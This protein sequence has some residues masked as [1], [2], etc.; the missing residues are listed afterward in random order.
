MTKK[1][2]SRGTQSLGAI[3]LVLIV[4]VAAFFVLG[5]EAAKEVGRAVGVDVSP[6]IDA[7]SGPTP[8]EQGAGGS[9]G[10]AVTEAA[11]G[12]GDFWQVYFTEPSQ[13][14]K[15]LET[16]GIEMHLID[17]INGAQSSIDFAVF[18]FNL[19]DVADALVA[20]HQR[21]VTVR[22]VYDNEHTV[23]DGDP[24]VQQLLDAG[25]SG[26]PDDRSAF[27]HNKFFVIDK[28]IVWTG[29]WNVSKNDTFRNN[30]NALVLRSSKL[31]ENYTTEF[32]N[33]FG[34]TFGPK[35]PN[36][37]PNPI[38]EVDGIRIE[39]YFSPE[40]PTMVNL[41]KTTATAQKSIH[42][43]AFSF[44]DYDLAKAMIDRA[45]AGVEV[46][47]IFEQRGS[48]TES[49]EC[50]TLLDAGIDT[51]IDG[52]PYTFHHKVVIVDSA[53]VAMGSFNFSTNATE[54]ND[55]NLLIIY[56]PKLAALYE[57]EFQKRMAEAFKPSG[58]GCK[59]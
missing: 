8:T 17:L 57:A 55:E 48:D 20:A 13:E 23:E 50:N 5:G 24:Q 22:M 41:V 12:T 33:M 21:G 10:P 28:S 32:E 14:T 35:K 37:T 11:S 56:D 53:I 47:G 54:S 49:A 52:N 51:R 15:D 9:G 43:M 59:K 31:A 2:S 29:S 42:F 38:L 39:N 4:I 3:V 25:V 30:N 40:G 46:A 34:G 16:G 7:I 6:L 1:R 44:T 36:N 26:T 58:P 19:Q 45:A 18:E 27:M